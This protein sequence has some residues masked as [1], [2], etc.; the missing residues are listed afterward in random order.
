MKTVLAIL[1]LLAP[2]FGAT[3]SADKDVLDAIEAYKQ[4]SIKG[5]AA[6]LGKLYHEGLAYTHSN[7]MTQTKAASIAALTKADG[8][9]K[10]V[11]MRDVEVHVYGNTAIVEYK[12]DLTHFKGDVAH[13]HEIMVW[14]K[15]PQGWQM[16]ARHATRLPAAAP[17]K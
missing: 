9:Y 3:G 2:A 6:A 7:G 14:M 13:L 10:G 1:F 11:D 17:A 5:D 15:S 12:L 16:L 8:P 4:A